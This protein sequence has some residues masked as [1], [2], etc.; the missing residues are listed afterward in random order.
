MEI[1]S[2]STSEHFRVLLPYCLGL[3]DP[4]S[5]TT[6]L[7][8]ARDKFGTVTPVE[9]MNLVDAV[10]QTVGDME[11]V[12]TIVT[13]MLHSFTKA[14]GAHSR[15]FERGFPFLEELMS[16]NDRITAILNSLKP[17]V[18]LMNSGNAPV[19]IKKEMIAALDRLSELTEHYS[20]KENILF[21]V[22]EKFVEE[23]RCVQLMWAIHDDVRT[24]LK[25]LLASLA[26]VDT[27]LAQLNHLFGQL[28]FDMRSMVFREEQVLFPA[29]LPQIPRNVL[30]ALSENQHVD[31]QVDP[32]AANND[33][34]GQIDLV[35]G[36]PTAR[37]LVHLFNNLPVDIT[38]VDEHDKVVYFNT[39]EH[40]IFPRT[41]AVIGR[42]VQNCHPPKSVHIV[43][44]ILEEFRA[45]T[46]KEAEFRI[47]IGSRYVRITY[48]ALY[49]SDGSYAGTLEVSQD[50]TG[51]RGMEGEK[52]LLDWQDK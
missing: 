24:T 33:S 17:Q 21:P 15:P 30:L 19:S 28:F 7:A 3:A 41:K 14:L 36:N 11:L 12:K 10:I 47:T 18:V 27:P 34:D 16:N 23:N 5:N 22:V 32:T 46:Q 29:I 50:I 45:G 51:F 1:S 48:S 43:Q 26:N 4:A 9:A 6:N 13:R 2:S 44:K 25:E 35:T 38:L 31:G 39:P 49:H 8:R 37:Q 20:M 40:R 52:R 42:T